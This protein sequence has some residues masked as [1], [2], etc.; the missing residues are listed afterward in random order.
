MEL[1]KPKVAIRLLHLI[2]LS[3]LQMSDSHRESTTFIHYFPLTSV[4]LPSKLDPRNVLSMLHLL[5][6]RTVRSERTNI[7]PR[8][9]PRRP[10]VQNRLHQSLAHSKPMSA[11]LVKARKLLARRK[12]R[13]RC[14]DPSLPLSALV[15][16]DRCKKIPPLLPSSE[17]LR[18]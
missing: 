13:A 12:H 2:G 6:R 9:I 7:R 11:P 4:V 14:L 16:M 1:L 3:I 15:G 17:H 18:A 5:V 10:R 8:Q